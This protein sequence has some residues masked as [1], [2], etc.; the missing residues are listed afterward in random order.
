MQ[1]LISRSSIFR[2]VE[3]F[4]NKCSFNFSEK[5]ERNNSYGVV[6]FKSTTERKGD[7]NGIL[8]KLTLCSY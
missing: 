3:T 1:N 7:K 2:D 5:S 4:V 8:K 6:K